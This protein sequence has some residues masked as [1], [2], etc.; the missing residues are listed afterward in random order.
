MRVSIIGTGLQFGRR[1]PVIH[2]SSTDDL[3][4]ICGIDTKKLQTLAH[5]YNCN[6]DSDWSNLVQ[7]DDIDVVII[8]TPPVNHAEIVISALENNKH[9]LCEKP[10]SMTSSEAEKMYQVSLK[11][12]KILKCG[13][14]HRHHPAMV[15]AKKIIT[16]GQVGDLLF[17]RGIYGICGREDYK[18][19]WRA[20]PEIAPG[21]QFIEQGT[22][23]IDLLRW[24]LGEVDTVASMVSN[25]YFIDQDMDDSGFAMFRFKDNNA[26]AS[27]H[28]S[29][30]Q[31]INT[32]TLELYGSNGYIKID[33]LGGGYGDH[34]LI[35]GIKDFKAPFN[36]H[37]TYFRGGDKS[38]KN[39]WLELKTA[40]KNNSQPMGNGYDGLQAMKIA[41]A[42]Y[43]SDIDQSFIKID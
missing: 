20:N 1:A 29:L 34:K 21:G 28:T 9:V 22:H 12:K 41:E 43:Q 15:N 31:W 35:V 38:W 33:G 7:R 23:M 18:N 10:L 25:H 27:F 4:S 16:S 26:T 11:T 24:Y 37:V 3:I 42:C 6:Y 2:E 39:E 17:A 40:I 13:F 19:E 14:N 30:T 32:F 36:E 8:T 5:K